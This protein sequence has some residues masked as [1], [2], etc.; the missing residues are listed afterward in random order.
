[1]NCVTKILLNASL[2]V[3][4]ASCAT[5]PLLEASL[6]YAGSNRGELEIVLAHYRN[7]ARKLASAEF[8]IP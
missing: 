8:L 1:M 3:M 2:S 6:D 7:D 5:D 4:M